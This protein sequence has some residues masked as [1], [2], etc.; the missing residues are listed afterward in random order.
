[1][2]WLIV[3]WWKDL[4]N[5]EAKVLDL[6]FLKFKSP[7][8]TDMSKVTFAP[9]EL[10]PGANVVNFEYQGVHA[11]RLSFDYDKDTKCG[12]ISTLK[13][14]EDELTP[15]I[16]AAVETYIMAQPKLSCLRTGFG[17][18]EAVNQFL[19]QSKFTNLIKIQII[20][21]NLKAV[22]ITQSISK[23]QDSFTGNKFSLVRLS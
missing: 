2:V 18:S 22:A 16:A 15:F 9:A 1:M 14:V 23:L 12:V 19:S 21:A 8:K 7:E 10:L 11:F 6:T 20:S 4:F 13:P 17:E 5:K 3:R